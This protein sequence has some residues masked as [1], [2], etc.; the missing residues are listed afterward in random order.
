MSF[1]AMCAR[2]VNRAMA[3]IGGES[4]KVPAGDLIPKCAPSR[5]DDVGG[6]GGRG[7]AAGGAATP[8]PE[9]DATDRHRQSKHHRGRHLQRQQQQ[10]QQQQQRQRQRQQQRGTVTVITSDFRT[11]FHAKLCRAARYKVHAPGCSCPRIVALRSRYVASME[12]EEEEEK[13]AATGNAVAPPMTAGPADVMRPDVDGKCDDVSGR[14]GRLR[15]AAAAT[16]TR[17]GTSGSD[18]GGDY[19]ADGDGGDAVVRRRDPFDGLIALPDTK[20]STPSRAY[21]CE[22]TGRSSFELD[23]T[24]CE[25][26]LAGEMFDD[27]GDWSSSSSASSAAP[28]PF[29]VSCAQCLLA[30][31]PNG[32]VAIVS[33]SSGGLKAVLQSARDAAARRRGTHR[34]ADHAHFLCAAELS[35]LRS[36]IPSSDGTTTTAGS[37]TQIEMD[38]ARRIAEDEGVDCLPPEMLERI[39]S[40]RAMSSSSSSSSSSQPPHRHELVRIELGHHLSS[41]LRLI[42]EPREE[43]ERVPREMRYIMAMG[44][45]RGPGLLI[46]DLPG[47]KRRLGESTLVG[48]IREVEE[49]CSLTIDRVW[50]SGRITERYGGGVVEEEEENV[51]GTTMTTCGDDNDVVD[52]GRCGATKD[53][54]AVVRVLASR[55]RDCHDVFLVMT[56]P[57]PFSSKSFTT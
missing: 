44:Y 21:A 35:S 54:N 1:R 49:E 43:T 3:D 48:A 8:T 47:G 23:R 33:R 6:G 28:P 38:V 4:A 20:S 15:L 45:V 2:T 26:K 29:K 10:Q 50:L 5:R 18:D 11:E 46:L 37:T 42:A 9:V 55:R 30:I 25:G 31:Q 27:R 13:A 14:F 36:L 52:G 7:E 40:W 12:E 56:P 51:K 16:A 39:A 57:P 19:D 32:F 24:G 34:H 53:E 17:G 22:G 41:L